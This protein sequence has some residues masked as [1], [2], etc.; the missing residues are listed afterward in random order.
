MLIFKILAFVAITSG[1]LLAAFAARRPTRLK[2]WASAYLV[3]VAGLIQLW[4]VLAYQSLAISRSGL[5]L[6]GLVIFNLGNISVLA[7]TVYKKKL[8][9]YSLVVNLGGGGLALAMILLLLAPSYAS[10]T[11][12]LAGYVALAVV[13][14]ITMPIGLKMSSRRR[15]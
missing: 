9:K 7:G 14:L 1:G 11:W 13:I 15:D 10:F 6:A 2:S 12:T 8:K 4:L 3:L 5:A